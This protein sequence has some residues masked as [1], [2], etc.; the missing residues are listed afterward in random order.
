MRERERVML[1]RRGRENTL[2]LEIKT[3]SENRKL[4]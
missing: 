2:D 1:R 4:K 3:H